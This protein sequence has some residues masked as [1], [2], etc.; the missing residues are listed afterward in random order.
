MLEVVP[1]P[2]KHKTGRN[3]YASKI[4]V[5]MRELK[6]RSEPRYRYLKMVVFAADQIKNQIGVCVGQ[7]ASLLG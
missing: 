4:L 6:A 7:D 5:E 3:I 1:V 2:T